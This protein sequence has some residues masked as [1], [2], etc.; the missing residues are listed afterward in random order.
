LV[1]PIKKIMIERN[2]FFINKRS[3]E[4]RTLNYGFYFINR[5]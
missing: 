4:N 5:L 3:P 2:S 1:K